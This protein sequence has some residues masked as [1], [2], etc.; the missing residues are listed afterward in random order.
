MGAF[1]YRHGVTLDT[2]Q[3]AL[4]HG[5]TTDPRRLVAGIGPAGAGKTTALRAI[6]AVWRSTGHR[7]VPLAPSASAAEVLGAELGCRAENLHKFQHAHIGTIAAATDEWFTL[8]PGDLLLVDEAGM[9]GTRLLDWITG[10]GPRPRR[11]R[12]AA[13]RPRPAHLGRSRG[14]AAPHRRRRRRRGAH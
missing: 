8:Q 10:Y 7:V 1:E 13:R 4:V 2:G 14:C 9:A 6:A 5:F 3:R 12:S 11:R